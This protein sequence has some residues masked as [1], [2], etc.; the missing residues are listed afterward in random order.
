VTEEPAD[1][2][3]GEAPARG[4]AAARRSAERSS[5]RAVLRKVAATPKRATTRGASAEAPA[6]GASAEAEPATVGVSDLPEAPAESEPAAPPSPPPATAPK[7]AAAK[8]AEGDLV[9]EEGQPKMAYLT[10]DANPYATVFIDGDR[11]GVTPLV[12]LELQ[13]GLHR[14]IARTEDG[15]TKRFTL[16]LDAG[17]TETL[18]VTWG[19]GE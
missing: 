18:K 11:K 12:R 4:S 15:R 9:I 5:G 3:A 2:S 10:V 13:P 1:E 17:K 8:P 7:A 14:M 16:Q 19:E 6:R